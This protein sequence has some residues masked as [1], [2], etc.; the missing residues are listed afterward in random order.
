MLQIWVYK[1]IQSLMF[2]E[3]RITK[4]NFY[5]DALQMLKE[6]ETPVFLV[7]SQCTE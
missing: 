3:P 6:E 2:L 4:H 1:C 7:G 5:H